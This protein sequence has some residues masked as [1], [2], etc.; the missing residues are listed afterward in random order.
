MNNPPSTTSPLTK[1]SPPEVLI[2]TNQQSSIHTIDPVFENNVAWL[3]WLVKW[4]VRIICFMCPV[5]V[6]LGTWLIAVFVDMRAKINSVDDKIKAE[7]T[8]ATNETRKELTA[9]SKQHAEDF[10]LLKRTTDFSQRFTDLL[11]L[12]EYDPALLSYNSFIDSI[13]PKEIPESMR[14]GIYRNLIVTMINTR[15]YGFLKDD[16]ISRVEK[17]FRKDTTACGAGHL[18]NI[19][20]LYAANGN[21]ASARNATLASIDLVSSSAASSRHSNSIAEY[22]A[23]ILL[24]ELERQKAGTPD[25]Q[26]K[27]VFEVF[28]HFAEK[29]SINGL[30]I[31]SCL[32]QNTLTSI[33][34]KLMLRSDN[35]HFADSLTRIL[36]LLMRVELVLIDIEETLPTGDK[37]KV[38]A[39]RIIISDKLDT[40]EFFLPPPP[41]APPPQC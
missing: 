33:K 11:C 6:V 12:G 22:I 19:S 27:I 29:H 36:R 2:L 26:V 23:L 30:L 31:V 24:L 18:F 34:D 5:L 1:S 7:V 39:R 16:E 17:V 3:S 15:R 25:E 28:R 20:L 14:A 10:D 41:P 9:E 21:V 32:R 37:V 40:K 8:T 38:K 35:Q 13:K 4:G